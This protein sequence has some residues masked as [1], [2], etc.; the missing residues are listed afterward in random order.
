MFVFKICY[1]ASADR[2]VDELMWGQRKDGE[3]TT[4]GT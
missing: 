3:K 1:A 2:F 4:L